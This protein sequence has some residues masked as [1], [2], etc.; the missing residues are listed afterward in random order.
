MGPGFESQRDH[1][2]LSMRL[3][4]LGIKEQNKNLEKSLTFFSFATVKFINGEVVKLVD[5]LL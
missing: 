2:S 5:T 4:F 1:K 3:L